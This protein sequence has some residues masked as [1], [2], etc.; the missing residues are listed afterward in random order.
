MVRHDEEYD[1]I[2]RMLTHR[3]NH[4]RKAKTKS[5]RDKEFEL[6]W[7]KNP[8]PVWEEGSINELHYNMHLLYFYNAIRNLSRVSRSI[9]RKILCS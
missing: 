7:A 5:K 9:E 8:I 3:F 2:T 1:E 4:K 6:V